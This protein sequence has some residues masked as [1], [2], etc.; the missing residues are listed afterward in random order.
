LQN[1]LSIINAEVEAINPAINMTRT[2]EQS[3]R[4]ILSDSLSSLPKSPK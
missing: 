4:E 1:P 2:S 3:K